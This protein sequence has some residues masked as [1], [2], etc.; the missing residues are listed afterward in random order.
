MIVD[1]FNEIFTKVKTELAGINVIAD[2]PFKVSD[3]PTVVVE[4]MENATDM[5]TFDS[6][7]YNHSNVTFRIEI[8]TTGSNKLSNARNIRGRV[9]SIMSGDYGMERIAS[10]RIKNFVQDEIERLQLTYVGKLDKNKRMYR[11]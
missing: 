10:N 1:V 6:S 3:F 11:R 7:G 9:D 5:R 4:E 8:F 2:Y